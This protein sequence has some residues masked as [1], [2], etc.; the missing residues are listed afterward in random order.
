VPATAVQVD[1]ALRRSETRPP[2]RP[3]SKLRACPAVQTMF[4]C[5]S[6][7]LGSLNICGSN[8]CGTGACRLRSDVR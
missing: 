5:W 3:K 4:F 2:G 8:P 6:I 1:P 7:F